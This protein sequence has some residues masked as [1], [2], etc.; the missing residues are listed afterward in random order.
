MMLEKNKLAEPC[1][2]VP[3]FKKL[4]IEESLAADIPA[5]ICPFPQGYNLWLESSSP[6]AVKMYNDDLIITSVYIPI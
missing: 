5:K 2:K 3:Q 4:W 6:S 1:I